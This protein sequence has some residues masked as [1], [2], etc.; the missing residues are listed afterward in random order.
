MSDVNV[1]IHKHSR[2]GGWGHTYFPG[3]CLE[4]IDALRLLL[5]PFWA[6]AEPYVVATWP[7]QYCFQ[8][9]PVHIYRTFAN[10]EYH[11]RRYYRLQTLKQYS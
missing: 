10:L 6:E 8:F 2:L 4:I 1:C 7:S 11:E 9:L 5:R 3:K